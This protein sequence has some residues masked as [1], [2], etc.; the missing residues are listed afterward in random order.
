MI[1]GK[2]LYDVIIT[3]VFGFNSDISSKGLRCGEGEISLTMM[4]GRNVTCLH[5][6][7]VTERFQTSVTLKQMSGAPSGR[8][9][10]GRYLK[11]GKLFCRCISNGKYPGASG[12]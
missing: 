2:H 9:V 6:S 7:D 11:E 12:I 10:E 1:I 5:S 3:A 4:L 8:A